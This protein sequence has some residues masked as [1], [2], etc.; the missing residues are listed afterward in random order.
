MTTTEEAIEALRPFAMMADRVKYSQVG[1][2]PDCTGHLQGDWYI[3]TL[4][5]IRHAKRVVDAFDGKTG[6]AA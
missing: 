3:I 5:D 4:G 2:L 1:S 6:D